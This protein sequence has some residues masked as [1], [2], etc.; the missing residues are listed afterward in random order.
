MPISRTIEGLLRADDQCCRGGGSITS[1]PPPTSTFW[2]VSEPNNPGSM[3]LGGGSPGH[4]FHNTDLNGNPDGHFV[5]LVG[6]T[7]PQDFLITLNLLHANG[8]F[9]GNQIEVRKNILTAG[10]VDRLTFGWHEVAGGEWFFSVNGVGTSL[11]AGPDP[12]NNW[13]TCH[14]E[15]EDRG[16]NGPNRDLR[17]RGY[18]AAVASPTSQDLRQPVQVG[19]LLDITT[20]ANNPVNGFWGGQY[21]RLTRQAMHAVCLGRFITMTGLPTGYQ[22]QVDAL[23]PVVEV[24]GVATQLMAGEIFPAGQVAVLDP[25]STVVETFS[26]AQ[27][28]A[29]VGQTAWPGTVWPGDTY[30]ASGISGPVGTNTRTQGVGQVPPWGKGRIAPAQRNRHMR[31][32]GWLR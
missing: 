17:L 2:T 20:T 9:G 30:A 15:L 11:A 7:D 1:G 10:D 31:F 25:S 23:A 21:Q 28:V 32:G 5:Q 26:P 13:R 16:P 22:L 14:F 19:A 6:L 24:G 3:L 4:I 27:A 8:S 12:L 18:V 29:A